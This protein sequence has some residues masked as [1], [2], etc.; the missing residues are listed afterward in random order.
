MNYFHYKTI[1]S[2]NEE[3]KRLSAQGVKEAIVVADV[4]DSGKGTQNRKWVSEQG[5]LYVSFLKRPQVFAITDHARYQLRIGEIIQTII[6]DLIG[7]DAKVKHPNDVLIDG[8]KCAGILM[9]TA[10]RS[11]GAIPDYVI[12]GIGINLNQDQFPGLED[13]ATSLY[14]KTGKKFLRKTVLQSLEKEIAKLFELSLEHLI[15]Q[16]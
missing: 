10:V 12:I 14:Q 8:K 7:L 6:H 3:A 2:T 11:G 5:G 9:E 13:I 15:C 1:D 16:K 4:Q